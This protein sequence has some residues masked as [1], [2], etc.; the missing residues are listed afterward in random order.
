MSTGN[1]PSDAELLYQVSQRNAEALEL[2]YER[3]AR[4]I[5]DFICQMIE[6]GTAAC[7]ILT[8]TFYSLWRE[9][10]EERQLP[11]VKVFLL[12]AAHQECCRHLEGLHS[13]SRLAD[14]RSPLLQAIS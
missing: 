5:F 1:E 8:E 10:N 6:P 3:H 14:Y 9:A 4:L 2:L 12:H 7:D 13:P 11:R